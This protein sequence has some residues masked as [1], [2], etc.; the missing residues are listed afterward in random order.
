M[1]VVGRHLRWCAA[2]TT[3]A[4]GAEETPRIENRVLGRDCAVGMPPVLTD[5]GVGALRVGA[6]VDE[7]QAVCDILHDTTL[8]RGREGM[9]ERRITVVLGSMST[10]ATVA[11]RRV[12]RIEIASPRFRTRD[13]LGVGTSVGTLRQ[14]GATLVVGEDANY[15]LVPGH[16]GL[17]FQLRAGTGGPA[18][19]PDS[20]R[21][22]MVLVTGC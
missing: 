11:D 18:S 5:S 16:C 10:T 13:S 20:A 2:V 21:V 7:V 12:W 4:C 14:R 3:W 8:R 9:P 15:A 19:V 17:S 6:R 1:I 22:R